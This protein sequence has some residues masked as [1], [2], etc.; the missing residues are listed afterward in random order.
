MPVLACTLPRP[1]P[2]L[3]TVA[4]I[5]VE[6]AALDAP[7]PSDTIVAVRVPAAAIA[8]LDRPPSA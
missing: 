4:D 1:A 6:A 7:P 8:M 5:T 2:A 3:T